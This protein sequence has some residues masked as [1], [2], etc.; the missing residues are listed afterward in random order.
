[1]TLVHFFR[2]LSVSP[3]PL[4][5]VGM[6][7]IKR[8]MGATSRVL[9]REAVHAHAACYRNCYVLDLRY[10]EDLRR[11]IPSQ[12][13]ELELSS[14]LGKALTFEN[15]PLIVSGNFHPVDGVVCVAVQK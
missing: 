2:S 4:L 8:G 13:H 9:A 10:L 3:P 1:M 6:K 5:G 11:N 15:Y 14:I 7:V 12:S